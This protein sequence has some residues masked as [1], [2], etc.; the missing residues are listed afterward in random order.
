MIRV[1]AF[2]ADQPFAW[3]CRREQGRGALDVG[4]VSAGQQ[5]GVRTAFF[6]D[7][8]MDFCR[9]PAARAANGLILRPFFWRR[10]PSDA[11]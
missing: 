10:S 1:V 6:V 5:E 4:D 8:R 9:A 2:V 11:P 3:R 7:E